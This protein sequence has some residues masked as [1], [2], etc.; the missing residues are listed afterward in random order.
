MVKICLT[1]ELS[2]SVTLIGATGVKSVNVCPVWGL[3]KSNGDGGPPSLEEMESLREIIFSWKKEA[4][5]SAN[6]LETTGQSC[7]A[8]VDKWRMDSIVFQ[9]D[10]GFL[11]QPLMHSRF[12]DVHD[13]RISSLAMRHA[14]RFLCKTI[15]FSI[16]SLPMPL[17]PTPAFLSFQRLSGCQYSMRLDQL[18]RAYPSLHPFRVVH[19]VPFLSNIISWHRLGVNRID[20]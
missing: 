15:W 2:D 17:E 13:F 8:G 9:S 20:S 1:F 12:Y 18:H 19:W 7:S 10:L 16:Q 4:S 6:G 3:S 5:E 14:S 11:E